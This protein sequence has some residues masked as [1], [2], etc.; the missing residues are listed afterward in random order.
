[1]SST[2]RTDAAILIASDNI[3][4]ADMIRKLLEDEFEKILI[5]VNSATAVEDFDR[6]QPE[7]IVLAFDKLGDSE[8]YYLEL[9]RRSQN[10][11]QQQHRT[12]ILCNKDEVWRAYEL[13][14]KDL[15]DDYILFW[16]MTH[17]APRLLMS[18]H[19]AI[20]ELTSLKNVEPTSVQF[21]S[22]ARHLVEL[23]VLLAQRMEQGG[24]RIEL[25]NRC[26]AQ[27]EQDL[28]N[29]LDEFSQRLANGDLSNT[30]NATGLNSFK[31]EINR[32]KQQNIRKNFRSVAVSM[33]PVKQW[34]N[35]LNQEFQPH[36]EIVNSIKSMADRT[37]A[38]VLV[39]DDD[40]FHRK[41]I[42]KILETENYHLEYAAS[43]VEALNIVRKIQPDLILMDVMMPDMDGME[44]T[45]RL[46][47]RPQLI[48]VPVVMTTGRSIG[49]VVTDSLKAGAID[50]VVKPFDRETLVAKINRALGS[51]DVSA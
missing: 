29:A 33:E 42:G 22:Q 44:T 48:N 20:R 37:R 18:V 47:A 25:A 8:R 35:E 49:N 4:D 40:D 46:K 7:V 34:A 10:I 5:S 30:L 14:R 50:F 26:I 16:P 11:Q 21:A 3:S 6:S 17:D 32:I 45:R 28:G 13:C 9:Y 51:V 1:M 24:A 19:L 2:S 43:G 39:V 27:V 15:F 12:I 31:Q 38:T 41:M 36:L 23:E